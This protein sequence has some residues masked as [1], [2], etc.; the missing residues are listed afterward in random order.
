VDQYEMRRGEYELMTKRGFYSGALE[1]QKD[2]ILP[3]AYGDIK[4]ILASAPRLSPISESVENDGVSWSGSL[5]VNVMFL[6]EDG[7]VASLPV[8]CEYEERIPIAFGE[9]DVTVAS[10]PI[11][12]NLQCRLVNPRKIGIRTKII[13]RLSVFETVDSAVRYPDS[14]S[15]EDRL[16][17]EER[18]RRA[19][20]LAMESYLLEGVESGDDIMIDPP[21]D[22]IGQ[23]VMHKIS[24]S[25]V[26]AEARNGAVAINGNADLTVWYLPAESEEALSVL[27]HT[28][29]VSTLLECRGVREGDTVAAALYCE[30]I[31]LVPEENTEGEKRILECDLTYRATVLLGREES[32]LLTDDVYS[33]RYDAKAVSGSFSPAHSIMKA[34]AS[35]RGS[36]VLHGKEGCTA[37][38]ADA[39]IKQYHIEP[40]GEGRVLLCGSAL[41]YAVLKQTETQKIRG[42]TAEVSFSVPF[43]LPYDA[44]RDYT[45]LLS[46]EGVDI[47]LTGGGD[48]SL[49][50]SLSCTLLSWLNASETAVTFAEPTALYRRDQAGAF[51]VYYPR[52]D[53]GAWDIAKKYRVRED[54]LV[55]AD[56]DEFRAGD[57]R[58]CV[59]IP[60]VKEAIFRRILNP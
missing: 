28:L 21:R 24:F 42:E 40:S 37:L 56:S 1:I 16:T 11:V 26:S 6:T 12:E 13:P 32:V 60:P 46:P 41:V 4:K 53:E 14:V 44:Q 58:R 31:S 57:K 22:A 39:V 59:M 38:G 7:E 51:T 20:Y 36:T 10:F 17:F 8:T 19:P 27:T 55:F 34:S 47:G 35:G 29:P 33:T 9:G 50:F 54:D 25:S 23:I 5:T 15:D 2:V 45:A 43:S 3:D 48:L 49:T 52:E 18:Y 30:N